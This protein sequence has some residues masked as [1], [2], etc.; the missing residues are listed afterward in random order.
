[1]ELLRQSLCRGVRLPGWFRARSAELH[2]SSRDENV[3]FRFFGRKGW[4]LPSVRLNGLI[5]LLTLLLPASS[6]AVPPGTQIDNTAMAVYAAG[7]TGAIQTPSNPV[8]LI[9]VLSRTRSVLEFM[10]YAPKCA[11]AEPVRIS[12]TY[13]SVTGTGD[14]PFVPLPPPTLGGGAGP[15]D[16]G[17]TVP[18]ISTG[19]YR[20]DE[21]VFLR[22]SDQDQNLTPQVSEQV[23]VRVTV[24]PLGESELLCLRETGP[25]TGVFAGYI[26]ASSDDSPIANNGMLTVGSE[27]DIVASYVDVEDAGDASTAIA[28]MDAC[29]TVFDSRTGQPVSDVAVSLI[30]ADTGLPATVYGDDGVS[31]F[32]ST[33]TSGG[34]ATDAGGSEYHFPPGGFRFPFPEPGT[35]RLEVVPQA[36]YTAPSNVP[37]PDLQALPGAPFAIVE[38]GSR[39][40]EFEIECMFA[41]RIDFPIDPAG[42]DLHI[43]KT[44][45][46][47]AVAIGD[48][49]EYC[50]T[51]ENTGASPLPDVVVTDRLPAGFRY[52]A[53]SGEIDGDHASDPDVSAD[54]RTLMFLLGRMDAGAAVRIRYLAEV[55]AGARLGEAVNVAFAVSGGG[56]TSNTADA[57]VRVTEDLFRT[58]CFIVGSVTA[59]SC[60]TVG[61]IHGDG[62]KG[63]RIYL[64]D[65]TWVITDER[66]M[67]HFEGV[68]PGVHVVQVDLESLPDGYEVTACGENNW[69]AGRTYSQFVDLAGGSQWRADFRLIRKPRVEGMVSLDLTSRAGGDTVDYVVALSGEVVPLGD[70]R[71]LLMLPDGITYVAG[72]SRQEDAVTRDPDITGN[73]ITYRL[74]DTAA[75]WAKHI[76]LKAAVDTESASHELITKALLVF[77]TPG[78]G[79]R[80]TPV[81]EN[82]LALDRKQ[83]LSQRRFTVRPHFATLSAELG[84]VDRDELNRLVGVLEG[85]EVTQIHA[86]GHTDSRPIRE[87]SRYLFRD[88]YALSLARAKSVGD[89]LADSLRLAPSQV[90][91]AGKGPDEP[92]AGNDTPRGRALNRRVEAL[93]TAMEGTSEVALETVKRHDRVVTGTTGP[94]PDGDRSG[95]ESGFHPV[96]R[97]PQ[98]APE[99]G[100]AWLDSAE[101]GLEWLWPEPGYGPPIP[102]LEVIVKHDPGDRLE[103]LLGGRQVSRVNFDETVE[104]TTG[105]VAM[106]RWTGVDLEEGDNHFE[107]IVYDGERRESAHLTRTIHYSGLP[108]AVELVSEES[109]LVANGKYPPVIAFRLTDGDGY[110]ARAGVVGRFSVDA[111]YI[112][113]WEEEA[114]RRFPLTGADRREPRFTVGADGVAF[115]E[116]EPTS[117]AGEVVLR[118]RFVDGERELCAWLSPEERDWILVGL[119]DGTVGYNTI[120]EHMDNHTEAGVEEDLYRDGRVA[121]FAKGRIKGKWLLTLAYDSE[122]RK[123]EAGNSLFQTID[124]DEYYTLYGDATRQDYETPSVQKLY[125]KIERR[126]FYAVFGDFT[127][128]LTITELSR[129]SRSLNGLKSE[130]RTED[131]SVNVFVSQTDQ[132]F[133]K[134]EIRG[135]GTSGI[136]RLSRSSIVVNSEKVAIETRDRFHS[137]II[138]DSRNLTRHIDYNIDYNAGTLFFKE[139]VP[140]KDGQLNPVTVVI[141][142]ESCDSS[143]RSYSYG[144]RGARKL[145]H[146]TL[147]VGATYLHEGQEGGDGDLLGVDATFKLNGSSEFKA[148]YAT[149][150]TD[151]VSGSA[152]GDAYVAEFK[153][154]SMQLDARVYM[155]EQD[156]GFGL[157]QQN[158]SESGTQKLGIDVGHHFNPHL[159]IDSQAYRQRNLSADAERDVGET[160]LNFNKAG[161]SLRA[162]FRYARDRLGDGT[163]YRSSQVTTG[164]GCS[165]FGNRLHVRIDHDQSL[166]GYDA[167]PDFPTR[168]TMGADYKLAEPVSVFAEHELTW[169]EN[170]NTQGSR[171]GLK[172][173]PWMGASVRSSLGRRYTENG[174]RVFANL[175]LKQAWLIGP[176]WS[177]DAGM[178]HSRTVRHPG[179][180]RFDTDVPPSS[181]G[182]DDFTAVSLGTAYREERWTANTRVELRYADDEDK[183]M[184]A[185][186]IFG[187]P[188]DGLG[189]SAAAQVL[190]A[191]SSL[192]VYTISSNLRLGM[193]YRPVASKWTLLDR[194]ELEVANR[195]APASDMD[196]RKIINNI[197]LNF[198]PSEATQ[199]SLQYGAKYVTRDFDGILCSGYTDLMG[200]EARRGLTPRWDVGIR[201][202]VLHSWNAN[203]FDYSTGL[204]LGLNIMKN[205]WVSTGYNI[206]GFEDEE[207]SGG[208]FTARGPF[209][210]L[211]LKVDQQSVRDLIDSL[212]PLTHEVN[213]RI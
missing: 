63:V 82:R 75:G 185:S 23:M 103:L 170:E 49:I 141:D 116:L 43:S 211:K 154:R 98:T 115:V 164:A 79:D 37:T 156:D 197:S 148:E 104:N 119:A 39:G 21:P 17:S 99:Y 160:R 140:S 145:L 122:K 174:A 186:G 96:H 86:E 22:L 147:E 14:G 62:V 13:Y 41:S 52:Q 2:A 172:A 114:Y 151:L 127:T 179:N 57:R 33:V 155:R 97:L 209:I 80:Q 207:F 51:V 42:G 142:F 169:G 35:Y 194:M 112:A 67:F 3:Q 202:G 165:V 93:V 180:T 167:N 110:P 95:T 130:L 200:L 7:G 159:S 124:P 58:M 9:T 65:G 198:K 189:M 205:V 176:R 182:G 144:G 8:T 77:D 81:V 120:E 72:S 73:V 139:P 27:H 55:A 94:G 25:D 44:V 76:S 158:Q 175:G 16:P 208:S 163:V 213:G 31:I 87:R 166:G 126:Q 54:G 48:F 101:P 206:F 19:L 138:L 26:E 188:R 47:L 196:S 20:T 178:D 108:V 121:L 171:L 201:G 193:V 107:I 28:W 184:V 102:S 30:D 90:T 61:E 106:S 105:T 1:M 109:R 84:R 192:G 153:H 128:G 132:A 157:G 137:E 123:A 5:L 150:R 100:L 46:E 12:I 173:T 53:G 74:G 143:D 89:Y 18:L 162:G 183:W 195:D 135:D 168:T 203:Q 24:S 69:F 181:G 92:L 152:E 191:I 59:D 161:H 68:S 199:M 125:L 29:G 117:S 78:G 32:P 133:V 60:D 146:R 4:G 134:D 56:V 177:V 6:H 38:P 15:L 113:R 85:S 204:S 83:L 45:N 70:L 187:E 212:A 40:G 64:E 129:Y 136:Y 88:N 34:T 149:S 210:R 50:L 190:R 66:G 131:H 36:G 71:L 111:P 91:V 118:F 11:G 10:R